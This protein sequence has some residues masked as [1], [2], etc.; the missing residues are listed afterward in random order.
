MADAA[1]ILRKRLQSA[2]DAK[3]ISPRAA[4]LAIGAN[5]SY[6]SQVLSGQGG[7]PSAAKV[8]ALALE[9]GTTVEYLMGEAAGPG[10]VGSDVA[11]SDK[12][13][14]WRGPERGE[15]GIPLMGT[16]DCA[17]I[18][19]HD[20]TNHLVAVERASFDDEY[21]VRMIARPP[22]LRGARDLYA[23]HFV[24]ES[25]EPRYEAG[26][27]AIVDPHRPVRAGD[28]VLVQLTNGED[29]SVTSVLAKRLVRQNAAE[30]V[31]EQFNPPLT[32][33]VPKARVARV[34]RIMAQTELLFG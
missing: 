29:P 17:A 23:I 11:L 6:V 27:V 28:Y 31:L 24:G 12:H 20:E 32:F 9:L 4:S 34:H 15:P 10:M 3:G 25:M 21:P 18:E 26:E 14:D 7:M 13:I 22:A 2:L 33:V 30:M 19:L 1:E 5:H 8:R 16:G